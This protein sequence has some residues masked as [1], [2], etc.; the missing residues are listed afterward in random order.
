LSL[1]TQFRLFPGFDARATDER[2][3]RRIFDYGAY[4]DSVE[5][6]GQHR[7]TPCITYFADYILPICRTLCDCRLFRHAGISIQSSLIYTEASTSVRDSLFA[8]KASW[9]YKTSFWHI[10]SLPKILKTPT[11]YVSNIPESLSPDSSAGPGP[12]RYGSRKWFAMLDGDAMSSFDYANDRESMF[13]VAPA[14]EGS[15]LTFADSQPRILCDATTPK[16]H[17]FSEHTLQS[18]A[19]SIYRITDCQVTMRCY[20]LCSSAPTMSSF[21]MLVPPNATNLAAHSRP[22]QTIVIPAHQPIPPKGEKNA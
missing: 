1:K 14:S 13:A 15:Y 4:S 6:L 19:D 10:R 9:A 21:V 16:L 12:T 8:Y 20:K 3:R 5:E 7:H 22:R 11:V 18:R 2:P 17:L